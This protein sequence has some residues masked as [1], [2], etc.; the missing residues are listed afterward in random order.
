MYRP[1]EEVMQLSGMKVILVETSWFEHW[2]LYSVVHIIL[3]NWLWI[4]TYSDACMVSAG[5]VLKNPRTNADSDIS[6]G[7]DI[8]CWES[9]RKDGRR[10]GGRGESE[11]REE[12][13]MRTLHQTETLNTLVAL[14]HGVRPQQ[15]RSDSMPDAQVTLP[16]MPLC[17]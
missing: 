10:N 1:V 7:R 6:G 4:H 8:R 16:A 14:A 17:I 12:L 11:G 13:W 3:E 15:C 5:H 2:R 9:K